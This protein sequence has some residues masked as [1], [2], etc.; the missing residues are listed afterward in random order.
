MSAVPIV[1][2]AGEGEK[3]WFAGGGVFTMKASAEETGGAF[4]LLEDRMVRGKTTPMHLHPNEDEAMFVLDG[5]LVAHFEGEDH[6]VGKGGFFFA[7][8]GLAHAFMVVS[9]TAHIVSFQTP[10][11][12]EPF[13]REV[14]EPAD[15]DEAASRPADFQRLRK[16][17]ESSPSIEILGPPP[18]KAAEQLAEAPTSS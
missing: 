14:S 8:R 10:G 2:Q 13:Y 11:S 6:R 9:E 12:G 18:F 17:A 7:P 5:E 1:R 3:L 4:F 16:A 15:S